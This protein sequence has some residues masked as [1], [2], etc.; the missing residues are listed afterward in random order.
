MLARVVPSLRDGETAGFKLY[1]IR[2][3]SIPKPL[4]FHNG[5][6]LETP[7]GEGLDSVDQA[8]TLYSTFRGA[9]TLELGLVRKGARLLMVIEFDE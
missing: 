1:G 4:G 2:A 9:T 5:D 6:L 7:D 3:G 8:I